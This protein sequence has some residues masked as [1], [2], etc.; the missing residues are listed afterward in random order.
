MTASIRF[1]I[2]VVSSVSVLGCGARSALSDDLAFD[3]ASADRDGPSQHV[4]PPVGEPPPADDAPSTFPPDPV[5]DACPIAHDATLSATLN[6][7]ADDQYRLYVNGTLIDGTPRLWTFSQQYAVQLFRDPSRRNAIAIEATNTMKIDGL[8]RGV[9]VDLSVD[10]QGGE[11]ILVTDSSWLIST[12]QVAGWTDP[13]FEAVGWASAVSE[14]PHGI[15]PW[16]SVFD[17]SDAQWI[18]SY[19]SDRA[20]ASKAELETIW[21]RRSFYLGVDGTIEDSPEECP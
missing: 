11:Q 17:T 13:D 14:G 1:M 19:D 4:P 3:T 8:D 12:K 20:S 2:G 16:G 21:L 18:W 7:T 9:I 10:T 5:R 6:I 15:R